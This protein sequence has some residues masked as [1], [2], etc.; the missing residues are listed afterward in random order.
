MREALAEGPHGHRVVDVSVT[1][2]DGKHHAVDSSDFAFR[3]AAKAVMKEAMAEAGALLLA[4]IAKLRIH[5]PSIYAGGLV[6]IISGL[7]GQVL[8]FE[9]HPTAA[10]WD[11][12]RAMLPMM[13]LDDLS[14]AL[15]SS[16]RGTGWFVA[17]FDHYTQARV[18]DLAKA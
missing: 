9:G 17:E 15:A 16:A 5:V 18:E 4:P 14:T 11:V 2:T 13:A 6:P 3:M 7:K 12:F 1:L 8:G 10:G